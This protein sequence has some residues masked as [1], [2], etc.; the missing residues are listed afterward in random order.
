MSSSYSSL[1]WVLSNWDYFTVRGFICVYVYVFFIFLVILHMSY[2]Y[3][4]MGG[5][6]G[7]EAHSLRPYPPSVL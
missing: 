1:D 3:N 4:T 6:G 2:Y 5:P 7:I